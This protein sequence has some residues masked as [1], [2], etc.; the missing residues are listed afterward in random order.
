MNELIQLKHSDMRPMAQ[1]ATG[2]ALYAALDKCRDIV[3]ITDDS[4][5]LQVSTF[6]ILQFSI[7]T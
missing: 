2:Q 7:L 1:A 3:L 6:A 4:Y 5:R